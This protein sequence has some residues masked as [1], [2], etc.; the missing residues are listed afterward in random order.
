MG[1]AFMSSILLLLALS[2][3]SGFFLGIGYFSWHA[4]LLAGAVLAPLSTVVLQNQDFDA[5]GISVIVACLTINQAAYAVGTIRANDGPNDGSAEPLPR[6]R[7]DERHHRSRGAN[8]GGHRLWRCDDPR[9]PSGAPRRSRRRGRDH[10]R[11]I[12]DGINV[13]RLFE[14]ARPED[15]GQHRA[16][17]SLDGEGSADRGPAHR[18]HARRAR[19]RGWRH[20]AVRGADV[21]GVLRGS[22]NR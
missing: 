17:G 11:P 18:V 16:R 2:E 14:V 19:S 22:R 21:E 13:V 10:P 4:V 8:A 7:A 5:S 20:E 9:E 15:E 12:R 6:Q 1:D 3:L